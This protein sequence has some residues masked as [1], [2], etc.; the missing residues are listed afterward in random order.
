METQL[1]S[2]NDEILQLTDKAR[3][4]FVHLIEKEKSAGLNLRIKVENPQTSRAEVDITFCPAGKHEP[5]DQTVIY[6]EF[7]LFVENKS[8]AAL[9]DATID[10]V[11]DEFGGQLSVKAPYIKGSQPADDAPLF[12]RINF[13]IG[14]E[15]NPN[16]A[17]HGGFVTL[18]E[19]QEGGKVILRFGGGCHGCGMVGVTLKSGIEQT[20]KDKFPEVTAIYDVTDHET[21]DNPYY[22]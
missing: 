22:S 4:H 8:V 19:I 1:E 6:P 20:L 5:D 11:E 14:N 12:D 2:I 17:S 21:G 10:Y 3:S 18:L 16:L 9:K 15:I 13:V 7:T